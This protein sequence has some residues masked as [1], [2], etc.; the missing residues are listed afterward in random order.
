METYLAWGLGLIGIAVLLVVV[1]IF[2]PTGGL[3]AVLSALTALA[4]IVSLF[5]HDV[6]WGAIGLLGVLIAAPIA[7]FGG[8]RIWESSPIGRRMMGAP[9]DKELAEDQAEHAREQDERAA[10]V[11]R[12]G[13]AV[14]PLRPVGI[15]RIDGKRWDA[16][17]ELTFIESGE[18]VV[19]T[20]A[21]GMQI[22]VRRSGDPSA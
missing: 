11:G 20:S 6:T 8:L 10:L 21:D 15:V 18:R 16:H 3:V 1:E 9:S 13:E 17:A 12:E 22:K 2:L 14:T 19:V 4:G 5:L 7:F